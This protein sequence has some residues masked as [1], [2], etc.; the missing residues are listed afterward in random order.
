[1]GPVSPQPGTTLP[2]PLVF[3]LLSGLFFLCFVL[4]PLWMRVPAIPQNGL[5]LALNLGPGLLWASAKGLFLAFSLGSGL[6]WAWWGNGS[7]PLGRWRQASW[8][9]PFLLF[10]T[11]LDFRALTASIPWRGDED[12]HI[13]FTL[14]LA[15]G[16]AAHPWY[17]VIPA[18]FLFWGSAAASLNRWIVAG[19]LGMGL[20][21]SMAAVASHLDPYFILRYPILLKYLTALPV[22]LLSFLPAGISPELPYRIIPLVSSAGLAWVGFI[23]LGKHPLWMRLGAALLIA[24]LPLVRFYSTLFYLEMPAVLCMTVVCF[25]ANSLLHAG[26]GRLVNLPGWYALLLVGFIKET[27]LPF[28]GAFI[29]SRLLCRIPSLLKSR[30]LTWRGAAQEA[31]VVFCVAFPLFLYLLYRSASGDSRPYGMALANLLDP[32]L[33][34]RVA[35][36]LAESFGPLL[37]IALAGAV[38]TAIRRKWGLLCF[39]SLAFFLSA[40]FHYLDYP[41]Y[42]GYSRF[43]LF[44]LPSLLA[45]TWLGLRFAVF[46][47]RAMAAGS[48][49]LAGSLLLAI[50]ANIYLSPTHSDGSRKSLWGVHGEDTGEHY[51][52]YRQA[53][54][55]LQTGFAGKKVRLTGHYYP[56]FAAFYTRDPD[57]PKQTLA[58]M[59]SDESALMDSLLAVSAAEG[60][61]A[62]LYHVLD[63]YHP[64]GNT[65]GYGS[66][67]VF[68]NQAHSLVLFS[69]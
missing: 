4:T 19:A 45:L 38:L 47:S 33:L 52:P 40:A 59:P 50:S 26:M 21:A 68:R 42:I 22:Y 46:R 25:Q 53:L 44:L 63:D 35:L 23:A 58:P 20:L 6:L 11:L 65:H 37:P 36:S 67:Q 28:L 7:P 62:V 12:H 10:A 69:R 30:T 2:R 18:L 1:M 9:L 27:A 31:K 13:V 51:Y 29:L 24:T 66:I 32:Q 3:F 8:I 43:N 64:P 14:Q 15:R 48:L 17:L 56:Y 60:Y 34:N 61:E 16:L 39:L 54:H 5:F 49:V 57:W 41:Q 55:R